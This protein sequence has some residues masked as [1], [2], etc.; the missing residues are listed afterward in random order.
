MGF[1]KPIGILNRKGF[2]GGP[3]FTT[4]GLSL[5]VKADA[6]VTQSGGIV[7]GWADQ[8][9]NGNNLGN[10]SGNPTL[11]TN[12]INGLPAIDFRTSG[13]LRGTVFTGSSIYAVV[14]TRATSLSGS[15][16]SALVETTGGG[17]YSTLTPGNGQWGSYFNAYRT[18]GQ[19]LPVDTS[20][21]LASISSSGG[22]WFF[23]RNGAQIGTGSPATY[24][25]RSF[26]YVGND[27][28]LGQQS[29]CYIAEILAYDRQL[30]TAEAQHIEAYL[31]YKYAIY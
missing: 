28:S 3:P 15:L 19:I 5:W 4:A 1:F 8:S 25:T 9:G 26:V 23:R 17:L 16:D 12:L 27:S 18:A 7:T 22:S 29:K 11:A 2:F 6:G 13:R 31:N 21:I 14:K 20:L 30:S 24:L 10:V